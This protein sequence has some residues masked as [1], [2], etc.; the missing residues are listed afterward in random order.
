[1]PESSSELLSGLLPSLLGGAKERIKYVMEK[2]KLFL[3]TNLLSCLQATHER[4][5]SLPPNPPFCVW[6]WLCS[7]RSELPHRMYL[8]EFRVD[9]CDRNEL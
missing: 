8:E 5:S 2:S 7:S 1:M 9:E 4:W 3:Y 6:L